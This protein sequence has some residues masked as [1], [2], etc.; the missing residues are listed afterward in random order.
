V[1]VVAVGVAAE[2]QH[3][4]VGAAKERHGVVEM[5]E[6]QH[7]RGR[8]RSCDAA[9]AEAARRRESKAWA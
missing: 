3:G 7:G 9:A 8:R 5:P 2:K 1:L 4:V 6:E